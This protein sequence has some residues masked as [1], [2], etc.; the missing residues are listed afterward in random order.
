MKK[1][2]LFCLFLS[3]PSAVYLYYEVAAGD[4]EAIVRVEGHE[5]SVHQSPLITE[6]TVFLPVKDIAEEAGYEIDRLSDNEEIVIY[7]GEREI[8]FRVGG[9]TARVNEENADLPSTY[10]SEEGSLMAETA[11]FEEILKLETVWDSSSLTADLYLPREMKVNGVIESAEQYLDTPYEFGASPHTVDYFDCSSFTQ[12]VY[13][14]N[15]I[16]LPRVSRNQIRA[17]DQVNKSEIKKGDLVFFDT[18]EDDTINHVAI[19][20]DSETLLHATDT[21]GVDYTPYTD[22]WKDSYAGAARVID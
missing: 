14:E 4:E 19:Y 3:V 13:K 15:G 6:G 10:V 22:Y 17:G 16:S 21:N 12:R 18:E 7:K 2:L 5:L 9:N 8:S 20:I 11:F 1:L